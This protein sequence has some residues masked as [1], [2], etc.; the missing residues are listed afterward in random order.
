MFTLLSFTCSIDY[1]NEILYVA[2]VTSK[3]S[4][5]VTPIS[6]VIHLL[7]L[8]LHL[9]LLYIIILD[10]TTSSPSSMNIFNRNTLTGNPLHCARYS[11]C[12]RLMC[13]TGCKSLAYE[14]SLAIVNY[15][16]VPMQQN[17][18]ETF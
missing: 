14:L 8:L 9:L 1:D 16:V 17:L 6:Q 10:G 4:A 2:I 3:T 18:V 15:I 5:A 12:I 13:I 11:T 7:L